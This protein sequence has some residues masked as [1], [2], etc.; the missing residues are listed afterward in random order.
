MKREH[1]FPLTRIV[2]NHA[3]CNL[4]LEARSSLFPKSGVAPPLRTSGRLKFRCRRIDVQ[5]P[6]FGV[7]DRS[8]PSNCRA[9]PFHSHRNY[10]S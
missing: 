1:I 7:P 9:Q 5:I 6:A 4:P 3:M 8:I 2:P 10:R